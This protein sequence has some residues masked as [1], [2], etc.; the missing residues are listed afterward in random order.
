MPEPQAQLM[1][2]DPNAPLH[3]LLE[4]L[5]QYRDTPVVG[6]GHGYF[7]GRIVIDVFWDQRKGFPAGVDMALT[8][9]FL[10]RQDHSAIFEQ[11]AARLSQ[12]AP[13]LR[14]APRGNTAPPAE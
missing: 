8:W 1:P 11:I 14:T 6:S 3:P 12:I 7:V 10:G 4:A 9:D 2:R 13:Q 5:Q